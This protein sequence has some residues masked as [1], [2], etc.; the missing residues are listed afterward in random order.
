MLVLKHASNSRM[1]KHVVPVLLLK[2]LSKLRSIYCKQFLFQIHNVNG[3]LG[4]QR[5]ISIV[6]I[7]CF[8]ESQGGNNFGKLKS[9]ENTIFVDM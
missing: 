6:L 3:P 2:I 4:I 5:N 8:H 9:M 1:S 7:D